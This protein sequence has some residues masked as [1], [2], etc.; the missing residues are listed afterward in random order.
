MYAPDIAC[1]ATPI[2]LVVVEGDDAMVRAIRLAPFAAAQRGILA[3]VRKS[4]AATA[5]F[6]GRLRVFDLPL[7]PAATPRWEVLRQAMA[8]VGFGETASFGQ[9]AARIVWSARALGQTC[10][11]NPFPIVVP[12]HRVLQAGS[13]LGPYSA[14]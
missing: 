4:G 3:T 11:R 9:L 7:A 14:G 6:A 1:V 8:D 5:Y 13:V 12:C 10:A 2:G